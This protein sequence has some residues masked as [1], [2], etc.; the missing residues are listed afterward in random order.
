MIAKSLSENKTYNIG[1]VIPMDNMEYESHFFQT[2][3][4]GIT[5]RCAVHNYDA[6]SIGTDKNDFS[7]LRRV[8]RNGK[9]GGISVRIFICDGD[10]VLA[11]R[12]PPV[13]R[14]TGIHSSRRS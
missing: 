8:V 6:L 10:T 4:M 9:A 12:S 13:Q 7:Q 3:L 1:I 11:E 2:C 14:R 5:R